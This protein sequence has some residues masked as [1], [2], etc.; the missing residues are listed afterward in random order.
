MPTQY[1]GTE[2]A[3][4]NDAAEKR[5]SLCLEDREKMAL[6]GVNEVENFSDTAVS[7]KTTRGALT[8][9][10]KGLTISRL[11]TDTGELFIS[12]EISLIRYSKD[13]KKKSL[14]EGLMK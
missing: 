4:K 11:N 9:Q 2:I 10:G 1:G 12:G 6:E 14:L 5:H 8:V 7:L 3:M 13:K